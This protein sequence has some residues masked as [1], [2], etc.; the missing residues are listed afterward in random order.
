M[1]TIMKT[2][3]TVS[4]LVF[5]IFTSTYLNAQQP[6]QTIRGTVTDADTRQPLPGC[7]VLVTG[8]QL[9][10]TTN[11]DGKFIIKDVPLGRQTVKISFV[12]YEEQV[13]SNLI[14]TAAKETI[15]EVRLTEYAETLDE[16]TV[17]A[18]DDP[19]SAGNELSMVSSR[20]F[21]VEETKRFAG[22]FNDPARMAVSFAGVTGDPSGNND[23]VI[24]GNSPKG[25]LWK[26]EGVEIPNPNH[27]GDEGGSGGG[28][29]MLN[30]S[31]L[32]NS[33]FLT[34]AFT[35]EYGNAMSGVFD[36]SLRNG[37]AYKREYALEFGLLGTD[38]TAEGPFR[39]EGAGSY[40]LNY[41]YSTLKLLNLIGVDITGDNV[42]NFQ[43]LSFK[44]NLPTKKAGT[45]TLF[46][47]GG[48]NYINEEEFEE[49]Q[50]D[51]LA[52]RGKYS[53]ITG[54]AGIRHKISTGKNGF[55]E[56]T[57]LYSITQKRSE[58]DRVFDWDT[59][60]LEYWG[61]SKF[62]NTALRLQTAWSHKF[63]S[64]NKLKVGVTGS[65]LG[66][67]M[68]D[69]WYDTDEEVWDYTLDASG[70]AWLWQGFANWQ[71]RFSNSLTANIGMHSMYFQLNGN[72]VVEPR[73]ALKWHLNPQ[74]AI[75]VGVGQHSRIEPLSVYYVREEGDGQVSFPNKDLDFS[76]ALHYVLGYQYFMT[77]NLNLKAEV[78]YQDLYNVPVKYS[79]EEPFSSL[80]Y[81][82]AY[83][84]VP[85]VNEG[86]GTNYGLEVTVE[87]FFADSYY[88]LVTGSLYNSTYK[89]LDGVE[90]NT[91]F[92]GNTAFNVLGGK[93]FEWINKKGK[94]RTFM[95]STKGTYAGG[96]RYTPLDEGQSLKEGKGVYDYEQMY[97]K[98]GDDFFRWDLQLSLRTDKAKST[99]TWKL[100]I[101]N[102]TNYQ[103]I[104]SYYYSTFSDEIKEN[105]QLGMLPVLSYRISF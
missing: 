18:G 6:L 78:Y 89:A 73:L 74:H 76:K 56:S 10:A 54:N 26:L 61:K 72:H 68:Y 79:L 28:I 60:I 94:K 11:Y 5:L 58:A 88:L 69:N 20:P 37:N 97:G 9:G 65:L 14:V 32:D 38:F 23:I 85:M 77:E 99:R 101:Q 8:V 36:I 95:V 104:T 100:D 53:G 84:T 63:N 64:K 43:D 25:M 71:H 51:A 13:V 82:A 46:G 30:S 29:S 67:N 1:K 42:P 40:L 86:S 105:T 52:Y 45:F 27:F 47:L 80:N 96:Q 93:E 24:R 70:S 98:Q 50:G 16:V 62:D 12:G 103:G 7:T 4:L 91:R 44:V 92:N 31:V 75:T 102:V 3:W 34:G 15:L 41:R 83:A 57:V 87:R 90:R 35:A 19:A 81:T 48:Y 66:F 21:T 39:K 59:P 49:T 22:S 17:E 2:N 33:D 55:L